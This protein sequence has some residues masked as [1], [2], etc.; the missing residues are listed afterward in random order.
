[1]AEDIQFI[2]DVLRTE[3]IVGYKRTC[4]SSVLLAGNV[5]KVGDVVLMWVDSDAQ[6]RK[7]KAARLS[8]SELEDKR[9]RKGDD[10]PFWVCKVCDL[11]TF[12]ETVST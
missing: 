4:Y 11:E 3:E 2:G 10:E 5:F 12:H 1:M 9:N 7:A 6:D 8:I